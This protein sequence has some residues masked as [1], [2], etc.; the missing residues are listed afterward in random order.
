MRRPDETPEQWHRRILR[1]ANYQMV[2]RTD[3]RWTFHGLTALDLRVIV[4]ELE[5][6]D[7]RAYAR[8]ELDPCQSDAVRAGEEV[9]G[10]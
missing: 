1:N 7:R 4:D 8:G 2:Q 10:E 6:R 9:E 5:A 3:G